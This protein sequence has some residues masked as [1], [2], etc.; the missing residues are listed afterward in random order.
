M[1]PAYQRIIGMGKD[2]I[3]IVLNEM[4]VRPGHWFWALRA[5]TGENPVP[6][7]HAGNIKAMSEDWIEWGRQHHYN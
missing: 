7:G 3:P 4:S 1:H 5:I 2:A 6:A